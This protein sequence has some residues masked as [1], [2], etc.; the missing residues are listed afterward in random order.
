MILAKMVIEDFKQFRGN[1]EIEFPSSGIIAVMGPNGAGKTTIFEAIE[2]CLYKPTRLKTEDIVP[3]GTAARPRVQVTLEDPRTGTR[4][5]VERAVGGGQTIKASVY[6]EDDLEKPLAQG[7]RDVTAF[8]ATHL[9]GLSHAAFVATFFTRQKELTYFGALGETDRRREVGRLL[10]YETIALAQ[11]AIGEQ[12]ADAGLRARGLA[13]QIENELRDR[14]FDV[15]WAELDRALAAADQEVVAAEE[16]FARAEAEWQRLRAEAEDLLEQERQDAEFARAEAQIEGK[17]QSARERLD[18]AVASLAN[19]DLVA[20]NRA[21]ALPIAAG[22]A[23]HQAERARQ[24]AAFA[25]Y[26]EQQALDAAVA[27]EVDGAARVASTAQARVLKTTTPDVPEWTWWPDG[28]HDLPRAIR[29]LRAVATALDPRAARDRVNVSHALVTLEKERDATAKKWRNC[30]QTL[31]SVQ[32]E[33]RHILVEGDPEAALTRHRE[34][35]Q[36]AGD[37]RADAAAEANGIGQERAAREVIVQR[38]RQTRFEGDENLCPTCRRPFAE[39]EIATMVAT[40]EEGIAALRQREAAAVARRS[41]AEREQ[42][43]LDQAITAE[44]ARLARLS[45]ARARIE[46]GTEMTAGAQEAAEDAEARLAECLAS[47]GR[48]A[49]PMAEE[50]TR[51]ER[52]ADA[53][54]VIVAVTPSLEEWEETALLHRAAAEEARRARAGLGDVTYDPEAHKAAE[55]AVNEAQTATTRIE[56]FDQQLAERPALEATR[57]RS[58]AEVAEHQQARVTVVAQ[59]A[60]LGFEKVR[61]DQATARRDQ[62]HQSERAALTARND[63]SQRREHVRRDREQLR[64][65]QERLEGLVRR[66][67]EAQREHGLLG[68]LYDTFKQF[69]QYVAGRV[70]PHFAEQTGDLLAT[71]TGGRYDHVT[72][73]QNYGIRVYDGPDEAF[74]ITAF[75]GG[76]HDVIALCARLALSRLVGGQAATPPSFLVL[77]EVFGALDRDRRGHVLDTLGALAGTSEA[78]RQLFIISHVDDIRQS[79]IFDDILRITE[80]DDGSRIERMGLTLDG[81]VEEG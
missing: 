48:Q 53:V 69:D 26:Q 31:E 28:S 18:A 68:E 9:V 46:R 7:T 73:D 5:L 76:E 25:R 67:D 61:L 56:G 1:Q 38:L 49:V 66:A 20:R 72:F 15:E 23:D 34:A 45:H 47:S 33:E 14:D 19:L 79:S 40:F 29:R 42:G 3:R 12:R 35:R 71:V 13:S 21:V 36:R 39:H 54:E 6:R 57:A 4:H 63:A 58:E 64:K 27:R 8:V 77:D 50:I 37:A 30:A 62:A 52:Y 81:P 32:A 59:R 22:L 2:W 80:E 41:A 78:Y 60:A 74:P 43:V 70:T 10:G 55:V 44:D 16:A 17:V 51:E 75:S 24:D 11:A 65:D